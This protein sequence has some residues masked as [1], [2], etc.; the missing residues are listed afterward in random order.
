MHRMYYL[1]PILQTRLDVGREKVQ[2]EENLSSEN[3]L[4]P[5]VS[6]RIV[7]GWQIMSPIA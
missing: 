1:L 7:S 4:N 6:T 3:I 5:F 2:T